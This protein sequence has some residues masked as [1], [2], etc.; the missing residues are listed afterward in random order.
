MTHNRNEPGGEYD[1]CA[2]LIE[3]FFGMVNMLFLD[4]N[5]LSVFFQHRSAAIT[6]NPIHKYLGDN[7]TSRTEKNCAKIINMP[8]RDQITAIGQNNFTWDNLNHKPDHNPEIPKTLNPFKQMRDQIRNNVQM[9]LLL[10]FFS[11]NSLHDP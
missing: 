9:Q 7:S 3:P 6:A 1:T 10:P 8:L 5:V 11:P 2:I 4:K